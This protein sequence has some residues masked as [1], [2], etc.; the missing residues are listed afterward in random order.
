[1]FEFLAIVVPA[2]EEA[3]PAAI[4]IS[5]MPFLKSLAGGKFA[6]NRELAIFLISVQSSPHIWSMCTWSRW[7]V[8][9]ISGLNY[10]CLYSYD[11]NSIKIIPGS[12]FFSF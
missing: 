9:H 12:G 3:W 10:W 6:R 4:Y 11:Y 7:S 1:M 5:A 2:R 8:D